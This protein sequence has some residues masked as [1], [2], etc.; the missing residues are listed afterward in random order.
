MGANNAHI[1]VVCGRIIHSERASQQ[2]RYFSSLPLPSPPPR[3]RKFIFLLFFRAFSIGVNSEGGPFFSLSILTP[4]PLDWWIHSP[5]QFE[6]QYRFCCYFFLCSLLEIKIQG[7]RSGTKNNS[8]AKYEHFV[9]GER[10]PWLCGKIWGKVVFCQWFSD[11]CRFWISAPVF[12]L[13]LLQ[14]HLDSIHNTFSRKLE[15]KVMQLIIELSKGTAYI[16]TWLIEMSWDLGI[17]LW[18]FWKLSCL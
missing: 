8:E 13:V 5:V 12:L 2:K 18:D 10:E 4:P 16:D 1:F 15:L 6:R 11:C 9:G 3:V 7:K 17:E 14:I